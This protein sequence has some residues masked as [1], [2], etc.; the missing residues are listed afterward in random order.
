MKNARIVVV[1]V[2]VA[3]L[4]SGLIQSAGSEPLPA[5]GDVP[6]VPAPLMVSPAKE[7]TTLYYHVALRAR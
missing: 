1:G 2:F 6:R 4:T 7:P 5:P 3:L